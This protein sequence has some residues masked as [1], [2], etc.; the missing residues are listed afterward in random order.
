MLRTEPLQ[1]WPYWYWFPRTDSANEGAE[2]G[3]GIGG[4]AALEYITLESRYGKGA[5]ANGGGGGNN[6]N[7]GGRRW[8]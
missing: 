3:E 8:I 7:A 2:K 5:P 4:S 1:K 6:H